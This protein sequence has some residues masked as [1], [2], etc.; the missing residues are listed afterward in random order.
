MVV[1]RTT[2]T[3]KRKIFKLNRF[4]LPHKPYSKLTQQQLQLVSEFNDSVKSGAIKFEIVPCLCG[5]TE[6]DLVASV[7]RY[8]MLQNTVLCTKCGLIF[9]NPRM[10]TDEYVNF[11]STDLYRKCYGG[12]DYIELYKAK[13]TLET[14]KHIF[15]EINKVKSITKRSIVLEFGAGGGWN[16]LPFIKAGADVVGMDYSPTL[17]NLGK[18]YGINMIQGS[19]SDIRGKFDVIILNHVAEHFLDFAGSLKMLANHLAKD[20]IIYIAVPNILN[21]GMGQL[22]NAHTYYFDPKTFK[23][24]CNSAGLK[25]KHVGS[26]EVIH[27]FGIFC[28]SIDCDYSDF[29]QNH[30][31][32]ILKSLRYTRFKEYTKLFLENLHINKT[33]LAIYK[34]LFKK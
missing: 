29:L 6:F 7:D 13:F 8:G 11:Y 23:H 20:A 27:M 4:H 12:D 26:A 24:Y 19:L 9:S 21:F 22:Q 15:D 14:G 31:E 17:V 32:E 3:T 18:E 1:S 34:N 28:S 5:N 2:I 16:L 30:Y 25:I 33:A 10:T